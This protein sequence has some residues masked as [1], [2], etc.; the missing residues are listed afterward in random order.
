MVTLILIF[1]GLALF[2]LLIRYFLKPEK[3]LQ[4][5]WLKRG[6]VACFS[7]MIA[8]VFWRFKSQI[9]N[10]LA[11]IMTICCIIAFLASLKII[12][13]LDESMYPPGTWD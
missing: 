13:K 12:K 7:V 10:G 9:A 6:A 3:K 11:F 2:A 8:L 1:L 5:E 4:R